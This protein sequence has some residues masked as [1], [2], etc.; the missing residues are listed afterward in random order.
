VRYVALASDYDGTLAKDGVV[1]P[2]TRN[3]LERFR[4]SGR[5]LIMVTGRELAD[6]E[7]VFSRLDLFDCI[8]AENGA[9]LYWP[10]SCEKQV[11]AKPPNAL[12]VDALK[13]RGVKPLSVGDSI[14][15]TIRP[16]ENVANEIIHQL[17]LELE[18]VLNK[19]SVMVLPPNVN[20]VSGLS[21]VLAA[22]SLSAKSV[23]GV[24]DA[25]NDEAFLR[26][27]GLSAAVANALPTV[28]ETANVTTKS[29]HGAGVVELIEMILKED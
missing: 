22:W 6:L 8:V 13:K 12:F 9:V 4:R 3:A 26:Y 15:A 29:S 27:C 14:V 25:E 18:I 17:G 23:V 1:A 11:L 24:G 7:S 19:G 2:E 21:A 10:G 16:N 5:R 20:K 28:K